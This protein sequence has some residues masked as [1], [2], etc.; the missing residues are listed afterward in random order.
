MQ[1]HNVHIFK[2]YHVKYLGIFTEKTKTSIE[3]QAFFYIEGESTLVKRR[4][5]RA[6]YNKYVEILHTVHNNGTN[7]ED[8]PEIFL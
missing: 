7:E 8:Y 5:T 6:T 3:I 4:F 1:P 2:E